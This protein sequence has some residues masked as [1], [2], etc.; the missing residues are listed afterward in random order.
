MRI[1][2]Y[3]AYAAVGAGIGGLSGILGIGGGVLLVPILMWVFGFDY[4]RATGTSLAVLAPPVILPAAWRAYKANHVDLMAALC[5]AVTLAGGGYLARGYIK[6]IPTETLRFIFGMVLLF[7]GMRFIFGSN[8]EVSSALAG[9]FSLALAGF[10][11]LA[12][13]A[14]G[15]RHLP[16]PS[17]AD[18]IRSADTR[19]Q[20]EPEYY[21]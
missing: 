20:S 11:F 5:I 17:L 4:L 16:P 19:D 18:A 8:R 1:G 6:H 21:I 2:L 7:L 15:R 14:L 13:R 12:L 10:A 3:L 9:L